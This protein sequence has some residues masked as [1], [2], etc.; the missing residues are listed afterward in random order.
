MPEGAVYVGRPSPWGN[1]WTAADFP[2]LPP[3]RRL[4]AAAEMFRREWLACLGSDNDIRDRLGY[5]FDAEVVDIIREQLAG[6]DLAC[7]CPLDQPCHADVLLDLANRRP[8][9]G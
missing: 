5:P 7:W 4:A 9:D 1:P 3:A 2:D 8:S 6:R